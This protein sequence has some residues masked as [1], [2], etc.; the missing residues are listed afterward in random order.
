MN[1][2]SESDIAR[3]TEL[4]ERIWKHVYHTL[5]VDLEETGFR[6][7]FP[8]AKVIQRLP[9]YSIRRGLFCLFILA[10][11]SFVLAYV[12]S[13][14]SPCCNF[15]GSVFLNLGMGVVAGLVLFWFSER[16]SRVVDGYSCVIE[17]MRRRLDMLRHVQEKELE[18]PYFVLL[19]KRDPDRARDW[20]HV[21]NNLIYSMKA[22][23]AYWAEM[24]HNKVHIG[25]AE[26]VQ[27]IEKE[28]EHIGDVDQIGCKVDS[29]EQLRVLCGDVW[30]LEHGILV[31]Y[32]H[33]INKFQDLILD[34]QFG[35]RP[36]SK[37]EHLKRKVPGGVITLQIKSDVEGTMKTK[38]DGQE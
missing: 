3:E 29:A 10:G 14:V 25:F 34:V 2:R 4:P 19:N 20:L 16:K 8:V 6:D 17:V 13:Q 26:M 7:P 32:E 28:L 31:E 27:E 9:V 35:C 23:M 15:W 5:L 22:H 12:L 33:I 38:G 11:M 30:R 36:L 18:D 24:L 1:E 21:H 37:W